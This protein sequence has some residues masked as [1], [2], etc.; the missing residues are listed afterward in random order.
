MSVQFLGD[1]KN[2]GVIQNLLKSFTTGSLVHPCTLSI[3]SLYS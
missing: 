3:F 1:K 2:K